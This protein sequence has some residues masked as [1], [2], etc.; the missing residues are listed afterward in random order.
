MMA[1][2]E[3]VCIMCV[4]I[5]CFISY[6]RRCINKILMVGSSGIISMKDADLT[7]LK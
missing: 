2:V 3:Y 5:E 6:N 1:R 7:I 4:R